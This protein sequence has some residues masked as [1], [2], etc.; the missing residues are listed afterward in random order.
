MGSKL[1]GSKLLPSIKPLLTAGWTKRPA[2]TDLWIAKNRLSLAR[3]KLDCLSERAEE[4]TREALRIVC[5]AL[6]EELEAVA[7]VAASLISDREL[8]DLVE[9]PAA[10]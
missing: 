6:R 7:A 5:D 3:L 2:L 4:D 1:V 9:P 8:A 10:D